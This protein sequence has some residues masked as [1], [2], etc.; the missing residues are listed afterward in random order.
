MYNE[1]DQYGAQIPIPEHSSLLFDVVTIGGSYHLLSNNLFVG[2]FVNI[3]YNDHPLL[4]EEILKS[5]RF[6]CFYEQDSLCD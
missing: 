5:D 2:C 6:D 3:T 4:P 1:L